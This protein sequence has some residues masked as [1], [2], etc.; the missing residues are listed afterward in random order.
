MDAISWNEPF[1]ALSTSIAILVTS[2][3]FTLI[4]ADKRKGYSE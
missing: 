3:D 1:L 2:G 4:M